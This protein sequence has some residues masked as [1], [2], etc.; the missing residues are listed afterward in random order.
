M[1]NLQETLELQVLAELMV[2]DAWERAAK[3]LLNIGRY[4]WTSPIRA[5]IFAGQEK[6]AKEG[7]RLDMIAVAE[8][9]SDLGLLEDVGGLKAIGELS[10]LAI[11]SENVE[12]HARQL[13][14]SGMI[15]RIGAVADNIR[16]AAER[17]SS[18][19]A[20]GTWALR[21]I[22]NVLDTR[23]SS[24]I[25]PIKEFVRPALEAFESAKQRVGE[26][27]GIRAGLFELDDHTGGWQPGDYIIL[28]A[29][30]S[31]GKSNVALNWVIEASRQVPVLMYSAEMTGLTLAQRGI[32]ALSN[33]NDRRIKRGSLAPGEVT[34]MVDAAGILS[35]C[36]IF[37]NDAAAPQVD[38]IELEVRKMVR[39]HSIGLVVIDYVG[40]VRT[41]RARSRQEEI[42]DVSARLKAIAKEHGIPVVALA[43]LN[44]NIESRSGLPVLSDLREAGD[45][46]QDADTVVFLHSFARSG[47]NEIPKGFGKYSGRPSAGLLCFVIAKQRTGPTGCLFARF[48]PETGRILPADDAPV[49]N[50]RD[51]DQYATVLR[52]DQPF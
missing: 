52:D 8:A 41:H 9:L 20:L 48:V 37:I 28:A 12:Q 26:A 7:K 13:V 42:A 1:S 14:E 25:A 21:E 24:R 39:E 31:T 45:L 38:E 33:L 22:Q 34:R 35:E 15:R 6:A 23:S 4:A 43:Q 40:K 17:S 29:R 32:G 3:Y 46:E 19:D 2:D 16:E 51:D 50:I 36:A 11:S 5:A 49:P 30:P 18:I 10:C 47:V 27:T 44:R